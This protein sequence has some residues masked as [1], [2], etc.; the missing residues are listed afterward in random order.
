MGV[1][2]LWV[3]EVMGAGGYGCGRL[4]VL[5]ICEGR[6]FVRAG[7]LWVREGFMRGQAFHGCHA[8]A[9]V[10][11]FASILKLR[12]FKLRTAIN[13]QWRIVRK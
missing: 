4:W 7:D 13:R 1:R 12:V 10:G 9:C 2:D 8:L 5:E 6:R 3:R 11:M